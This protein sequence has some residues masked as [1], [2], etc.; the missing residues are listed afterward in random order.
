M[1]FSF[2]VSLPYVSIMI[3]LFALLRA[4]P[5]SRHDRRGDIYFPP[6]SRIE[7]RPADFASGAAAP[8]RPEPERQRDYD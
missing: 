2:R 7:R 8:P 3:Y 4:R 6:P 5:P 1:S